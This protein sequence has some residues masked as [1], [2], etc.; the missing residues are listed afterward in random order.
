MATHYFR[1]QISSSEESKSQCKGSSIYLGGKDGVTFGKPKIFTDYVYNIVD[2]EGR[3]FRYVSFRKPAMRMYRNAVHFVMCE[4]SQESNDYR[5]VGLF[6]SKKE[7]TERV[8]LHI[9]RLDESISRQ[10]ETLN[11]MREELLSL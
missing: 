5:I 8:E 1:I 3:K 9:K 7:L 6:D 4:N 10:R 2:T 11:V